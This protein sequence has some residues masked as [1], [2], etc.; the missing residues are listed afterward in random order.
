MPPKKKVDLPDHVREAV[1]E[2]VAL[3]YKQATEAQERYKIRIYLAIQQ[4]VTTYEI[5]NDLGVSQSVVSKWS[6]EGEQARNR[7]L[8]VD[9]DRSGELVTNGG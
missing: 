6:R 1:L 4:G 7:R 8:G 2:D 5:A 9:P 3:D